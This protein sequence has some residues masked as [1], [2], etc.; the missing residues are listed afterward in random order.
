ELK[1]DLERQHRVQMN[2]AILE[3]RDK[4]EREHMVRLAQPPGSHPPV[5]ELRLGEAPEQ[6]R[7]EPSVHTRSDSAPSSTVR[8][9]WAEVKR[10]SDEPQPWTPVVRRK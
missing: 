1:A 4:E 10:G 3:A 9:P 8:D 2:A 5:P 7:T 6:T